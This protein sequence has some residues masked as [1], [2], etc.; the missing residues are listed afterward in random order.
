MHSLPVLAFKYL[1]YKLKASNGKGHGIHSPFVFRFVTEVLNDDRNFYAFD[2]IEKQR[3]SL[4]KNH[5]CI[6]VIDFGAGSRL[7]L[8]KTRKI[9][10][11]ANASLKPKKYSTLL[12]KIINYYGYENIVELGTCL[13]IT[14]AYL[15]TANNKAKITTMEGAPTIAAEASAFFSKKNLNN[16]QVI[17]GNF[18]DT[19]PN[20][21]SNNPKIDFVYLDGNHQFQP[22]VNYFEQLLPHL[23]ENAVL[24]FDDIYWSKEMEQAWD[25]V[26]NKATNCITI[27]LFYIGIVFFGKNFK[28]KEHFVINY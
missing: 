15:A 1:N 18:D 5:D 23:T 20:F 24:I 2:F 28:Q 21:L 25:Y 26:K 6:E 19:L 22:T 7:S 3:Q 13:G 4:L 16:I 27:D 14:T 10:K 9:S 8:T 11:I 12:F 17:V